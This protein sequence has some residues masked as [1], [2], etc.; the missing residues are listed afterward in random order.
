M[1]DQEDF[2]PTTAPLGRDTDHKQ[3][4]HKVNIFALSSHAR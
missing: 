4:Q 2:R 1:Y 3:P